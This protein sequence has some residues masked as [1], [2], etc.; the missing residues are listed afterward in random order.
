MPGAV[1][2]PKRGG[3]S[4]SGPL[5]W[6]D[7]VR[8]THFGDA[9][10]WRR[11][12]GSSATA[13]G[14]RA[15]VWY[16][17]DR[18]GRT[19]GVAVDPKRNSLNFLRLV[20]AFCVVYSHASD[21]GW[22]GFRNVV[23]NGNELGTIAVYGFFGI[24]GYLIAGSATRN[25]VGRYL[26]QR[27]LRI[28]P[29]FWVCLVVTA[30]AF[31]AIA[32]AINPLPHCGYVCYLKLHPGPFSFVYSNALLKLNQ[33]NVATPN[34]VS[35]QWLALDPVLRVLVLPALGRPLFRRGAATPWV[36]RPHR[37]RHLR[38]PAHYDVGPELE[39]DVQRPKQLRPDELHGV[40]PRVLG[41]HADISLSRANSRLC[42]VGRRLHHRVRRNAPSSHR[43]PRVVSSTPSKFGVFLL[44][45]PLLW[46]GA[47][48]PFYW[49]GSKNDYSYGVY[50]YAYP[51]TQLLV[52]LGA[53]RVGFWPFMGL[54]ASVTLAFAVASWWLVEKHALRLKKVIVGRPI[55]SRQ[56]SVSEALTRPQDGLGVAQNAGVKV[57]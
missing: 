45:Y 17:S 27:F 28:F 52:S 35:G 20:L 21:L 38:R 25:S 24:S 1:N 32:L 39:L 37:A 55:F 8:I 57:D 6:V 40:V 34:A 46:L 19:I 49:I 33:L 16:S 11:V 22:W 7:P 5:I 53:D 15:T 12:I 42:P 31:G 43:W 41:R 3:F 18:A 29:A 48:L 4:M 2:G 44:A 47:H 23:V 51:L 26:W 13:R 9:P 36:G 50:I 14:W 10:L 30:F 56:P 54:T